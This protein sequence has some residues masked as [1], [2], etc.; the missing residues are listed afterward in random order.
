MA[1]G[2]P[3]RPEESRLDTLPTV[4]YNTPKGNKEMELKNAKNFLRAGLFAFLFMSAVIGLM[5]DPA[6]VVSKQ[7]NIP[8]NGNM[9]TRIFLDTTPNDGNDR[10][11]AYVRL[12]GTNLQMSFQEFSDMIQPGDIIDYKPNPNAPRDGRYSI[13]NLSDMI[14]LNERNIYRIFVEEFEDDIR[15][16]LFYE[17]LQAY[18]TQQRVPAAGDHQSNGR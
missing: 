5:A 15:G 10:A 16:G 7:E 13:I 11:D 14:N 4:C 18:R 12:Y 2:H 1:R 17:S 8:V 9:E 3:Q 6:R